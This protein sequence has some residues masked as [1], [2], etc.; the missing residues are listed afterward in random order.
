V[1][2]WHQQNGS[3]QDCQRR[4]PSRIP[5]SIETPVQNEISTKTMA[6]AL[7]ARLHQGPMIAKSVVNWK[8]EKEGHK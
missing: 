1:C 5:H 2:F 3:R 6:A 8:L 7:P 4:T